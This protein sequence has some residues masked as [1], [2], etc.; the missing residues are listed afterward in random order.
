MRL[1]DLHPRIDPVLEATTSHP[2]MMKPTGDW[3]LSFHCPRCDAP[4]SV[5]I[6]VGES[7]RDSA[8]RRWKADP[9]PVM[10][11]DQWNKFSVPDAAEW[12]DKVTIL[13]SINNT[14]VGHG[15][16]HPTCSFHGNIAAGQIIPG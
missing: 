2:V 3:W 9:M 10:V 4:H 8:K 13:P 14:G 11:E 6:L 1:R 12:F 5:S 15:P 7:I 16:K